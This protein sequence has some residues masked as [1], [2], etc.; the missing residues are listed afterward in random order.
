MKS[1]LII[2]HESEF[3]REGVVQP[4]WKWNSGTHADLTVDGMI[5]T[6]SRQ[7][8]TGCTGICLDKMPELI[9]G[10]A[11]WSVIIREIQDG[12]FIKLGVR[13]LA[14]TPAPILLKNTVVLTNRDRACKK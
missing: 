11:V 1:G 14:K 7:T 10:A 8:K 3:N 4:I 2:E 13:P 9:D 6:R 5:V 12:S